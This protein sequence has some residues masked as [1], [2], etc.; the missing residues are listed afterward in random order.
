MR[1]NEIDVLLVEDDLSQVALG[2]IAIQAANNNGNLGKKMRV[3]IARDGQEAMDV[4]RQ[5]NFDLVL[6]DLRMP[7]VDGFE[8]LRFCKATPHLRRIPIVILTTSNLD[9]DIGEALDNCANAYVVKPLN[10]A[11]MIELMIGLRSFWASENVR[12]SP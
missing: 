3:E 10:Q 7:R 2:K 11:K 9:A 5:R 6:L 8:V 4:L 12:I 1:R